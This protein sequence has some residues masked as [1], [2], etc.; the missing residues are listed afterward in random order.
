MTTC[1]RVVA[2]YSGCV[3]W[4][5]A[6]CMLGSW[7]LSAKLVWRCAFLRPLVMK[8]PSVKNAGVLRNFQ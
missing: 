2:V 3:C 7:G 1:T 5:D 6:L 4:Y 8:M